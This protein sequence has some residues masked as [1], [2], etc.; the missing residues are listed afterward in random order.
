MDVLQTLPEREMR[1]GYAEVVKYGL[2]G[3][4]AFYVWLDDNVDRVLA[5]DRPCAPLCGQVQ[6]ANEGR[7]RRP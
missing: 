4:R 3:D 7:Y 1:A 6:R 5:H 2:L